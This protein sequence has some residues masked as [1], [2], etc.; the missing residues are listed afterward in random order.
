MK[1]TVCCGRM[2]EETRLDTTMLKHILIGLVG[3]ASV[4]AAQSDAPQPT[5][6]ELTHEQNISVPDTAAVPPRPEGSI[7]MGGF[8]APAIEC[9]RVKPV[10]RKV[11]AIIHTVGFV[12]IFAFAILADVL[13]LL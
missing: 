3:A 1:G 2:Y 5:S 11:E 8:R 7:Y 10:N 12:L 4:A 6:A 9:V 13:Q